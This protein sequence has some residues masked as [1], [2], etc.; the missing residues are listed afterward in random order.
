MSTVTTDPSNAVQIQIDA[1]ADASY[2]D[3]GVIR[4]KH[5]DF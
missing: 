5:T 4:R 2:G 3:L 1:R